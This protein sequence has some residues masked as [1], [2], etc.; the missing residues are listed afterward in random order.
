[1]KA[2]RIVFAGTPEFAVP[3]LRALAQSDHEI[4]GVLTRPDRPRGR[5]RQIAASPVKEAALAYGF[6]ICQPATLATVEERAEL[7][8]WRPQLLVV[9]AYGLILPPAVLALPPLGCL[10]IHA[11]LLP[12]WRGAAPIQRAILAGDAETGISIM[13]MDAGLDTGPVLLERRIP[14]D[15]TAM[16]GTLHERLAS[17]GAEALLEAL[18]EIAA[19][20][21]RPRAQPAEGAT[22]AA[23]ISKSEAL[24]D[25]TVPARAIER[26]VRAFNPWPG[27]QTRLAGEPLR[28]LAAY[29][30]ESAGPAA[31][32]AVAPAEPGTLASAEPGTIAAIR[33]DAI[34]VDCGVGRLALTE[35]QRPGRKPLRTAEFVNA[36]RLAPGQR[37]G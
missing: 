1:M 30:E 6:P 5:G 29:A 17:L 36:G 7:E 22:Y 19:G 24:I 33:R 15:R 25:W 31:S 9:V 28:I 20:A 21:A 2:L 23:K 26:Q 11:S 34:V 18:G 32:G 4:V 14:I 10:N 8:R 37:L 27:A 35:V 12:R 16:S 3:A 13:Q